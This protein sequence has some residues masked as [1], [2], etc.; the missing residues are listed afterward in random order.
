M[1]NIQTVKDTEGSHAKRMFLPGSYDRYLI[2]ASCRQIFA[3]LI[4]RC[5]SGFRGPTQFNKALKPGKDCDPDRTAK[6]E[7]RLRN[8][9]Q[10]LTRNKR[11]CKD[12]LYEDWK[13]LLLV[14]HPLAYDKEK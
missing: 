8:V 9:I 4:D 6:C 14:N 2:E 7:E 3:T 12:V 1:T 5:R 13:I 10:A 11:V